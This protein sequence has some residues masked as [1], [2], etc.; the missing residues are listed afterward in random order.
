MPMSCIMVKMYY[1]LTRIYV[2]FPKKLH[3]LWYGPFVVKKIFPYGAM[4]ITL[5]DEKN[6][7]KVKH[8]KTQG[9]V[10]IWIS[11]QNLH[12]F[13]VKSLYVFYLKCIDAFAH[14]RKNSC[15][16]NISCFVHHLYYFIFCFFLFTLLFHLFLFLFFISLSLPFTV[17]FT[18]FFLYGSL[19][20]LE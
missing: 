10:W 7:F 17:F 14:P 20:R 3:S 13:F 8:A 6:V 9:I 11:H 1:S 4:E 12:G 5:L 18:A 15:N 19:V 2:F 16:T